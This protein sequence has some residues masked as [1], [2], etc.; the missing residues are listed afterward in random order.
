MNCVLSM[1]FVVQVLLKLVGPYTRVRIP[2]IA[3]RLNNPV[4]EVERLLVSLILDG[5]IHGRIDQV[6][7]LL[8]LS[9]DIE[10]APKYQHLNEW[11]TTLGT[12]QR[13]LLSKT[14][15]Y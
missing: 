11:A 2:F 7:Q 6:N 4:K 10:T 8:V 1:R 5:R 12:I 15:S 3:Q 14:P 9:K 13:V